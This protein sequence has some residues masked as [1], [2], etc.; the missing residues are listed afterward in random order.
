MRNDPDSWK[1]AWRPPGPSYADRIRA[2]EYQGRKRPGAR[3]SV[4]ELDR[5]REQAEALLH[6][7]ATGWL[8]E[9]R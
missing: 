2:G 1:D 4:R 9:R 8:P 3:F 6:L 7:A 5:M